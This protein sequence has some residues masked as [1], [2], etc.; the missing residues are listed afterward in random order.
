MVA[1][2]AVIAVSVSSW[3]QPAKHTHRLCDKQEEQFFSCQTSRSKSIA[4]CG[5]SDGIV[6]YRYGTRGKIELRYPTKPEDSLQ[7]ASYM[8]FQAESYEISF[9]DSGAKYFVFEYAEDNVHS[10][11]VRVV[12]PAVRRS[13][14]SA[15]ATFLVGRASWSRV[16]RATKTMRSI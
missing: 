2:C 12:K 5:G 15:S 8:R 14:L 1:V 13:S 10:A 3:A 7:Y 4:L 9:S 11:G 6:Q 16:S